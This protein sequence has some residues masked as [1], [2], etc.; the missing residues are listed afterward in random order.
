MFFIIFAVLN[1]I[2]MRKIVLTIA[3]TLVA[4]TVFSQDDEYQKFIE[5]QRKQMEQQQQEFQQGVADK[6]K[7]YQDFV[8]KQNAEFAEFVAKDWALFNE[9]A[10]EQLAMTGPKIEKAPV[11]KNTN[12]NIEIVSSD[13]TYAVEEELPKV[14]H[15][16]AVAYDNKSESNNYEQRSRL[17]AKGTVELP[18]QS[19]DKT[20]KFKV[21]NSSNIVLNFYGREIVMHV[22]SKLKAKSVNIEEKNVAQYFANI[23]KCRKETGE[24]WGEI[25]KVVKDFG[26]NEWGYFCVLRTLSEK[27]FEDVN[28][29]VLFCFYMLRNEGGFK[30]RLARGKESGSLTLLIALDNSKQVYSYTYFRFDDDESGK[31]KVKYYTVYGGGKAKEPVYSYDFCK[32]DAEKKQM[33]LDFPNIL[34]MGD[35]DVERTVVLTKDK[36]VT[37]PYNKAHMAYLDDVPMTVFP[38]YFVSPVS[39]EAQQVL[40]TTF[41]EMKSQYTPTQFISM[42]LHF[43]QTGFDYKTDEEQFGYEK[44]FYP[45]E[46]IGYP[47][48][49]CEDRS[50]LFAWLVQKY[51]NAQ[52]IGLQY[53][54]H[55]A[56]AVYFGEDANVKGD[57]FMYGG[58]KFYVCDPTYINAGIGMAMPQYKGKTPKIIK[59]KK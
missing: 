15:A 7:E 57:G 36:K 40:Q 45:E 58:K 50:A 28:D 49:D 19:F 59:L 2:N 30:T 51:T 27:M 24:L 8:D 20:K 35:C 10:K 3:L 55:V 16:L 21:D 12:E 46:V 56:T 23:A 29:R 52:V 47:Y 43:V 44:Y 18:T 34:N 17:D 11:A 54:G 4:V 37:L 42:L 25:D 31:N 32:Q 26:L 9:F 39:I 33:S 41:N 13:V 1:I 5:A 22:D 38:I 53:E 48:C 14:T 6:Q